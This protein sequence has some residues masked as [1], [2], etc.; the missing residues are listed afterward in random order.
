M[1]MY[2]E[3]EYE[4]SGVIGP[5]TVLERQT[6]SLESDELKRIRA[7]LVKAMNLMSKH[8]NVYLR[9]GS[10]ENPS[11]GMQRFAITQSVMDSENGVYSVTDLV[12]DGK[13]DERKVG[14]STVKKMVVG[15]YNSLM[16][17]NT[18]V[19]DATKV[20]TELLDD[21]KEE[22]KKKKEVKKK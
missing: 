19:D 7:N 2:F 16:G 14:M 4:K 11:E 15:F 21:I 6:Y 5:A 18:V 8:S 10:E 12:S 3:L 17:S 13:R 9:V 1:R 20:V 22:D